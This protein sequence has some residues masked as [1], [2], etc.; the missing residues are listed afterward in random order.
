MSSQ[1]DTS[2]SPERFLS[3]ATKRRGLY[4][5][6]ADTFLMWAGFFMVVPLISIHYVE[7]LGWAG[8][9]VGLALAVRQLIQQGLSPISGMFADRL[10]AKGLIC[11]GLAL[12]A[13]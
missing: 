7:K 2:L 12:R 3:E 13:A 11:T 4:T 10:G 1:L 6:L 9:S 5:I 8:A